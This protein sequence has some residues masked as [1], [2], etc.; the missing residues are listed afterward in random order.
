M[1]LG[2]YHLGAAALES[3][4]YSDAAA[5]GVAER[6]ETAFISRGAKSEVP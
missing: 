5:A 3:R 6:H 2:G 4:K 1:R